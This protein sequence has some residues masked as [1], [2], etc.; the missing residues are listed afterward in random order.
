M[1]KNYHYFLPGHLV[2]FTSTSLIAMLKNIGFTE[3][4]EYIPVDFSLF[5]K[6]RKSA[7]TLTSLKD[8]FSL[9]KIMKYHILSKFKKNRHPKT[10]SYVLYAFK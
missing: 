2:Y 1:E 6:L 7:K 3:F 10:S 5:A 9:L 4:K 8:F